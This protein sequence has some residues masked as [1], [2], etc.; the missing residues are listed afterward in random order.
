MSSKGVQQLVKKVF[1][2]AG[3]KAK[4]L[5]KPD[6]V[7]SSYDLTEEERDAILRVRSRL[8]LTTDHGQIESDIV[9][10]AYWIA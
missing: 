7:L 2:D 8:A 3:L 9:P 5:S 4:F 10:L 1:S 6:E